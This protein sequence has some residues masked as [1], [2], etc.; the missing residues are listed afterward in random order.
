MSRTLSHTLLAVA[1]VAAA[2]CTR[3]PAVA[4]VSGR[5][6]LGGKALPNVQVEFW[7][8]N[9]APRSTGMTDAEGRFTLVTDGE[10]RAGALVGP[11]RV[12]LHDLAIYGEMGFRPREDTNI[13]EKPARFSFRYTN[14]QQTPLRFRVEDGGSD[15]D[16]SV[17]K[18]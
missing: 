13:R 17:E 14:A 9:G 6:M 4:A 12:V 11:H 2:G 10:P 8:E 7:P 1:L 5:V 15:F 16:I 18:K 3:G